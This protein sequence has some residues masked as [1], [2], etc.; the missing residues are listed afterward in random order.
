MADDILDLDLGSPL[1]VTLSCSGENTNKRKTKSAQSSKCVDKT[2]TSSGH[3]GSSTG[4][5]NAQSTSSTKSTSYG[6]REGSGEA[7]ALELHNFGACMT[8]AL[9][10]L[11]ENM[12]KSFSDLSTVLANMADPYGENYEYN[13]HQ[14]TGDDSENE[15]PHKKHKRKSDTDKAVEELLSRS[16]DN[17]ESG[18]N[19][20]RNTPIQQG[21]MSDI[22]KDW[23][24]EQQCAPG[25]DTQLATIVN[26]LLGERP[27]DDIVTEK[28]ERY[29]RPENCGS[30][31]TT[32]VNQLIWDQIKAETR[33][34]EVK[35]QRVQT[36]IIKSVT[37]MVNVVD[38]LLKAHNDKTS[39]DMDM[40]HLIKTG[41]D[42]I[43]LSAYANFELNMRRREFIK[44]DLHQNYR[45]LCSQSV[46]I[47]TELF[48]DELSKQL[49][50]LA[51][52]NRVGQQISNVRGYNRGR[53]RGYRGRGYSRGYQNTRR[54]F[55]GR[56]LQ[57]L[58]RGRRGRY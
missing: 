48:G 7:L 31:V 10:N 15:P 41:T 5:S 43:A 17:I 45:H 53:Y 54:P 47:T 12:T 32:R 38:T 22:A 56:S 37:A 4:I 27:A 58:R 6:N 35:L 18:C 11:Q 52:A 50:D 20:S 25:V 33:T 29:N 16:D 42:A 44:P 36:G 55:L 2:S 8:T 21:L 24:L 28:L 19:T 34:T 49:K 13:T 9:S 30:L 40:K 26:T 57:P 51:E 23:Q 1:P 14:D 46:P 3:K 39:G